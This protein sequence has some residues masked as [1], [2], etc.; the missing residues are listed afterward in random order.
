MNMKRFALLLTLASN[1]FPALLFAE[2]APT[3]PATKPLTMQ[4]DLSAQMVAG[5]DKFLTRE[6][7]HSIPERQKLWQRNTSSRAA[8]DQSV[9]PNRERFRKSIGLV[10][11][12]QSVTALEFVGDTVNPAKVAETDSYTVFAVRWP[13]LEMF[14]VKVC[15][16]DQKVRLRRASSLCPMPIKHRKCW[17]I[18]TRPRSGSAV[19][20]PIG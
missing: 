7:D 12:R 9:E 16:C 18:V 3:L 10:D 11:P 5:I 19:C 20:T 15:C 14:T 2:D 17:W 8:Y 4:G 6:L 13:V 1:V